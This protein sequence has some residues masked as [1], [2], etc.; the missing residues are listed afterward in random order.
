MA[1][2]E[3]VVLKVYHNGIE[4]PF[5]HQVLIWHDGASG[6]CD[7]LAVRM[8]VEHTLFGLLPG[9]YRVEIYVEGNLRAS[10]EFTVQG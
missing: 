4:R 9:Q 1:E 2:G 5:Y 8:P 10:G 7:K 3:Q 6:H